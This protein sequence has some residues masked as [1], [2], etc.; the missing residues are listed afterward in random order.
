MASTLNKVSS[1][2]D[3]V[4]RSE[5][6]IEFPRAFAFAIDDLGWDDGLDGAPFGPHRAGVK[7]IFDISDY[8]YIVDV[9][10]A[11]G[12]RVQC[13]FILSEFDRENILAQYPTTTYMREKWDNKW[14]I[15]DKHFRI[16][17]FVRDQAA[18]MEFGFHGTGHEYW[19]ADGVQRRAEWFNLIDRKP[20]PED[21]LRD[22][23]RAFGEIMSQYGFTKANG[24][25]FPESFVPCAYSYYWNP[26]GAYSLG[27]LLSE[28]GV[29]YANT[30]FG[31]IQDLDPPQG[32]H[33]S[34]FDHG[35]HVAH[36]LNYGNAWNELATLPK[37]SIDFQYTDF[38]ESH[39]PNWLAEVDA[40]QPSVTTEWIAYYRSV[41]RTSHRYIAKNTEQLHSQ[42]LYKK[43]TGVKFQSG[44]AEIDN[45]AMPDEAYQ[46]DKLGNMVLKIQLERGQHIS[47]ASVNGETLPAYFEDEGFGFFYLPRLDKK[48]YILEYAIGEE[49]LPVCV[50]NDGTYNVY[51][52]LCNESEI[53]ITVRVYGSQTIKVRCQRPI[54][55]ISD[56]EQLAII[57][58]SYEEDV[59][60]LKIEV[61]AADMQ[62]TTSTVRLQY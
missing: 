8:Q 51:K 56:S 21:E 59:K 37:V 29:K 6:L 55:A 30:D 22:H 38:A 41:Q 43:Y 34:G 60:T 1:H 12:V 18:H 24:H 2:F 46:N 36:R 11:V 32:F 25:S 47:A 23:V 42:S 17:E 62:G 48:K 19:P 26:K 28:A 39:W 40:L 13:L 54:K 58:S 27:K 50:Y 33:V 31:Q 35:V 3:H 9:A 52:L 5:P 7:R 20:W 14:R 4:K 10:R 61:V 53:A 49:M 44:I 45:T 57:S 15:T 16:M